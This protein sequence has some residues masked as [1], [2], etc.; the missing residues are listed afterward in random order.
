[1]SDLVFARWGM[2]M[3]TPEGPV[4][5]VPL[6][7]RLEGDKETPV[8]SDEKDA[9]VLALTHLGVATHL[10]HK[11]L[12]M[13][14]SEVKAVLSKHGMEPVMTGGA[15]SWTAVAYPSQGGLGARRRAQRVLV[16]GRL[17]HPEAN[18]GSNYAY[19]DYFCRCV[20]CSDAHNVAMAERKARKAAA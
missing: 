2:T 9:A 5:L 4:D 11:V 1:M 10:M 12:H 19:T 6:F 3:R 17:V 15:F 14:H 8:A 18:H 16:D 13:S 20:P 7:R